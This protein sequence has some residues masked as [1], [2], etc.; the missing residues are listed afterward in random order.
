MQ[1]RYPYTFT[2]GLVGFP[3]S[4]KS[5][6]V[7]SLSGN[8]VIDTNAHDSTALMIYENIR[9]D[10]NFDITLY[11]FPSIGSVRDINKANTQLIYNRIDECDIVFWVSDIKHG[12][13]S[14][15]EEGEYQKLR[16]HIDSLNSEKS[17]SI[18]L[19][20]LFS[21]AE[22]IVSEK[23]QISCKITEANTVYY[24][25]HG[26]SLYG[27]NSSEKLRESVKSYNPSKNNISF[28]LKKII[29]PQKSN[30][31]DCLANFLNSINVF[32]RS[33]CKID[34]IPDNMIAWCPVSKSHVHMC[35][36]KNVTVVLMGFMRCTA[37]NMNV[38]LF[39]IGGI[40]QMG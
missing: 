15:Y 28:F 7:N 39:G 1:N 29:Y 20:V 22:G 13:S 33:V 30:R 31:S 16:G 37:R 27:A 6:I 2:V 21:K 14:I 24:N 9:T 23:K 36:K 19:I 12:F 11:D 32:M 8:G 38:H 4:G 25:A 40:E 3:L 17:L 18:K 5:S 10:D 34:T 26:R 35:T